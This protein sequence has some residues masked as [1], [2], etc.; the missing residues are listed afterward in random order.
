MKPDPLSDTAKQIKLPA[1]FTEGMTH[2]RKGDF[3]YRVSR[4]GLSGKDDAAASLV[5]SIAD[6][7]D[8]LQRTTQEKEHRLSSF[9]E[10]LAQK[11]TQVASGD[12]S[13]EVP[14]DYSGDAADVLAYLVN[15][16]VSEFAAMV[17]GS[18]QHAEENKDR[19]EQLVESRTMELRILAT[20]DSLTH[21]LNRHRFFEV[22]EE[23]CAR[24]R[25]YN[26][27]M[28]VAMLDLDHFKEINDHHGHSVGDDALRF[29]AKAIR[30]ILRQQDQVCRYGGEEFVILM[31]ETGARCGFNV[32]ER[33]RGEIKNIEL[34]SGEESVSIR[35]SVGV[36]EWHPPETIEQA[37][38]RADENMYKAKA[39]GR[40]R[41][42]MTS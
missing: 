13:V 15:T 2:I 5:N 4:E 10:T 6:E 29:T 20:T 35:V 19:L 41:V 23:E 28:T 16:T 14:R 17:E 26:R 33:V 9:I 32:L 39:G 21:T 18:R 3:T 37:I 42:V 27:P 25:R 7:L 22:A 24:C 36:T 38:K 30:K 40:D 8:R 31:P 34:R 11:L 1:S 12:F